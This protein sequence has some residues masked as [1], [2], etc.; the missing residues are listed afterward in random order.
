MN[1]TINE[2]RAAKDVLVIGAYGLIGYGISQHLIASGHRV[3][4]LGRSRA[5]ARRVMPHLRWRYADV[6]TMQDA[7]EWL[8]IL[9]G[10]SVVVNCSGAL[11]DGP[12]DDLEALHHHAVAALASACARSGVS[13][14]QISAIGAEPDATTEFLASK[15]RGD[16]A[17]RASGAS[18]HILRPGLVL[19]GPAYGGTAMLRTLAAVP[20]LQPIAFP[21]AEI[22]TVALGD[23]ARV[24]EAAIAGDIPDGT[25]IDLIE[26]DAHSLRDV[27][28]AIRHWLGFKPARLQMTIP[29]AGAAVISRLADALSHLGW[30][31]PLRTTALKVLESG[32]RG[33]PTDLTSFGLRPVSSLSETLSALPVGAQDR[34][35][36]R[37]SLLL[38]LMLAILGLFWLA[39]GVIALARLEAAAQVLAPLGWPEGLVVGNIVFWALVDIAI[40]LALAVRRLARGACMAAV[41]VSVTYLVSATLLVPELWLDPLGPLVKVLPSIA[42]ALMIRAALETR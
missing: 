31:S 19:A 9:Q 10:I 39:S 3:T 40:G 36:A 26:S 38:P 18:F 13:L 8:P 20:V 5:T 42:L 16:A 27:L 41:L 25:T 11:Q 32:V 35:F 4:G 33:T 17:I 34:L 22:Q 23:V 29:R 2:V 15:A 6:S 12:D 28:K 1:T 24:V 37:M 30:R 7:A 21:Q 14:I